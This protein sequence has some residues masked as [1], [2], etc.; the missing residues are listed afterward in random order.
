MTSLPLR[1]TDRLTACLDALAE[2]D[3]VGLPD[4]DLAQL[5]QQLSRAEA[6]VKALRLR[7][8]AAADR[9]R[10]GVRAGAASTAA[11]A[12][13]LVNADHRTSQRDV[14]LATG[15]AELSQTGAAL[16]AGR[17]SAEHA[18]VIT[19]AHSQLPDHLSAGEREVVEKHLITQAETLS[20]QRLRKAARRAVEAVMPDPAA[21]DAHEDS[22]LRDE[23]T[24]ARAATRLTLHDNGDGTI[25]GHFTVPMLHGSLL[26]KVLEAMTAPRRARLGASEAQTGVS[27]RRDWAHARGLAFCELLEHVPTDHLSPRT[28][29]QIVVTIDEATLRDGLRAAGLDTGDS[30]SAGEA[31]RLACNAGILPAVLGGESRVLDLGRSRRLFSSAQ[32]IAVGLRHDSCAADGCERPFAWCELHHL[33]PWSHGGRTDLKDAVP[34]CHFHHQR[35]H[36]TGFLHARLPDGSI[37]FSRRT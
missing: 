26:Q 5:V 19:H 2:V 24:R 35:I 9:A 13:G 6:R 21:V 30:L 8:V 23:E 27:A 25:T 1:A 14:A 20:P 37:R 17:I 34:L 28:A 33:T 18:T 3:P 31:R 10:T 4:C 12:A 36:D 29:A 7:V 16:G 32:G 11:W 15:L 22:V